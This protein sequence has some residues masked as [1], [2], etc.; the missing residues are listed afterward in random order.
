[1]SWEWQ[2]LVMSNKT[3]LD[4]FV[5]TYRRIRFIDNDCTF[6]R[7]YFSVNN[8]PLEERLWCEFAH[9]VSHSLG[10]ALAAYKKFKIPPEVSKFAEWFAQIRPNIWFGTHRKGYHIDNTV[11]AYQSYR[12]HVGIPFSTYFGK[13]MENRFPSDRFDK[14]F[15]DFWANVKFFGRL[16]SYDHVDSLQKSV[17]LPIYPTKIHY[18]DASGPKEG[19]I[20]YLSNNNT[21]VTPHVLTT[22]D[23]ALYC[24]S[25]TEDM[26]V[27]DNAYSNN[28]QLLEIYERETEILR[29][30]FESVINKPVD[31]AL[32]ETFLCEY[33]RIAKGGD[34]I[35][36]QI[37]EDWKEHLRWYGH[38]VEL[39]Q[40]LS[41]ADGIKL[42]E[43]E[44]FAQI[45]DV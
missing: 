25:L 39:E 29:E 41:W 3:R 30:Q 19:I 5:E 38:H 36:R 8:L 9:A 16:T 12:E 18:R 17:R 21:K 34:W 42:N 13:M 24:E 45:V 10:F 23:R 40:F 20:F 33:E 14:L 11:A 2:G 37:N 1:M 4:Q 43:L 44:F 31:T 28:A 6:L 15:F 35:V 32:L 7:W 27:D 26:S 22:R